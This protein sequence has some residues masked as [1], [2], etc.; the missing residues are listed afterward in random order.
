MTTRE[1]PARQ[2]DLTPHPRILPMLG[3]IVLPQ[4][5][6][7]AELV[8]NSIDSFIEAMRA[9]APVQDPIVSINVPTDNAR[10]SRLTVR[11]NGPGMDADILE[12][13]ARAGWTSHDPINN[14]GLFG[15]GF[16][17]ATARLGLRTTIWT[18]RAGQADWVGL[19]IDFEQL[20]Q[21]QAF[22]TPARTRPKQNH[23]QSGTEVII[24]RLKPEQLDWFAKGYNRSNVSKQ[25]GRIY[26]SMLGP[27]RQ[28][29]GFRLEINGNQV[30]PKLHCIWGGPGNQDR[31]VETAKLGTVNAFQPF[32][33]RLQP[34]PFCTQC[35]N[36]LGPGQATCPSCEASGVIVQRERRVHGWL[37]IQRFLDRN[38][39]G[40]D[41]LRN[42]RKIEVGNKDL[43]KWVD[44]S[45]DTEEIEYPVD[46]PRDRGRIVGEVHL[47]HCRVPYTKDRFVREDAA[48]R[49][50]VEIVRGN[51]PLRPDIAGRMGAGEN[52]SPLYRLFQAFRRSN[53]HN[54]RAGGWNR[55]L[56]V[57]DNDR[58]LAMAR[59]FDAGEAEYQ[60]DEKWWELVEEAEAEVF[61]GSATQPTTTGTLGGEPEG[62]S[63]ETLGGEP[64][65][66]TPPVPPPEPPTP[67]PRTRIATLTRQYTDDLTGQRY[68]VEAFSVDEDDPVLEGL[69]CPWAIR[70]TTAGPWEFYV[71]TAAGA[72]R[73]MTL[74]PLDALLNEIAWLVSDFERGLGPRH[75]FGEILMGLREKYATALL[76]D[77]QDLVSESSAQLVDI[78]RS[79]VGRISQDDA[80][81]FFDGLSPSRQ[82]AIRVAMASRGVSNPHGAV[83]DGRFLQY[84]SPT[85]ISEF[86]LKNPKLFFDGYYWDE[87]Y[88]ALDYGSSVATDEAKARLLGHYGGL[89]ADAVWLAQQAPSDLEGTSR[90]RLMRASLATAL[91]A[92]T[93]GVGEDE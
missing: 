35:W 10:G 62:G 75:S 68:D 54:R 19:E 57:P 79:I 40:I 12:R 66:P 82:E 23:D 74:T 27:A 13:A 91:L 69:R 6:C 21:R 60:T 4:W 25:L 30:R 2:F 51:T 71:N 17:I 70:R 43:F 63:T 29:I 20:T 41:I 61:R 9:G 24:E 90:E 38:E 50:M 37:G 83:Y 55:I 33:V 58:A 8:D 18:T 53:P 48:W 44:E 81:A 45:S 87:P 77:P 76:L 78:A 65:P 86:V 72:F 85:V 39:Y 16:N 22:I 15:M 3:E 80:Q 34:R 92:R 36:W 73:S 5:R 64:Q 56:V 1:N 26:S 67:P 47:D 88:A 28:P 59:R 11:D 42:G 31:S 46:D 49:E 93:A 89:L 7:L 14:L 32:D 52:N 84:A